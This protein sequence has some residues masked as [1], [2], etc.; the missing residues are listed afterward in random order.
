[1]FNCVWAISLGPDYG[2]SINQPQRDV[3]LSIEEQASSADLRFKVRGFS[4]LDA[5]MH[6]EGKRNADRAQ[7]AEPF[8]VLPSN[9]RVVPHAGPLPVKPQTL[10]GRSAVIDALRFL[11]YPP[12]DWV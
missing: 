8:L 3:K 7:S 4:A 10:K 9:P 2:W 6:I 5:G 11:H 1:M 12:A